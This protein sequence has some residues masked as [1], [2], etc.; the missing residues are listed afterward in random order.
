VVHLVSR[1]RERS[2]REACVMLSELASTS[3]EVQSSKVRGALKDLCATEV[4][5]QGQHVLLRSS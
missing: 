5:G 1:G 4:G 2:P 3:R